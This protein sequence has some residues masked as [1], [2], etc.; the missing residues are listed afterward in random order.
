MFVKA[1]Y[2]IKIC[3]MLILWLVVFLLS[4]NSVLIT[5]SQAKE[6]NSVE[7]PPHDLTELSIEDLMNIE[8][9]TFSRKPQ[10]LS[11]TAAAAFVI[12][13]EDIRRSGAVNIPEVLRMVPGLQVARIDANKWAVTSRGFN[14][15]FANKLLVLMDGRTVYTPFFSGVFWDVQDTLMEDIDRIE[16]IRGPG[17][18]T[19]GANAVNGVINIITKHSKDTQ[20]GLISAGVGTEEKGFGSVRYGGKVSD[21]AHVRMYA[22]YFN[23]DSAVYSDSTDAADEW[24]VAR[25]GFRADWNFSDKNTLVVQGDI[26]DGETGQNSTAASLTPPYSINYDEDTEI[27]GGNILARWEHIFSE[28]SNMALKMYYDQASNQ[29]VIGGLKVKTL[30]MDF[31]H[32]FV[33]ADRNEIIWGFGYRF[34]RDEMRNTF[35]A[36]F[37]PAKDSFHLFS[38]F[39]QDDIII[40]PDKWRLTLGSKFEHNDYTGYEIQPTA[41]ILWTPDHSN[42]IWAA[43]SRA[44]RTPSRADSDTRV[45]VAVIPPGAPGNPGPLPVLIANFGSDEFDSEDLLAFEV[46]YRVQPMEKL[47]FD[48]AVFYN[49]YKHLRTTETGTM[50]MEP[51]SNPSRV[52]LPIYIDNKMKGET[53]GFELAVD[54]KPMDWW[55]LQTAYTYLEMDLELDD[56]STD[57][58]FIIAEDEN[59]QHQVSFRSSTDLT[60][61]LE[62]DLWARFVDS[63]PAQDIDGYITLD[64]RLGWHPVENFEISVIGQNLLDNHHPEFESELIATASTEVERS[65]YVKLTYLF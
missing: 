30:D 17:A 41:R 45:A 33:M 5:N 59:P 47:S 61:N 19:W 50:F 35:N 36:S 10:K 62:L 16:I 7:G 40:A 11:R 6:Y 53:Y 8:V 52:V 37:E 24:D 58:I 28:T 57:T 12:T 63:L 31:Q 2:K 44:V 15:R 26:Y 49:I 39:I 34:I 43:V 23:R 9:T 3:F 64:A 14:G 32:Q 13:Q 54:W 29:S 21:N 60:K 48:T 27:D 42:S 46:G 56:D 4:T 22:K 20:G 18:S 1:Q 25:G 55:R 65:A 51:P 38:A